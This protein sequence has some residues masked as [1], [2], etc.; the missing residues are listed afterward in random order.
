MHYRLFIIGLLLIVG[1]GATAQDRYFITF[2]DKGDTPYSIDQPLD[3]LSQRSIDRRTRNGFQVTEDDLP[4]DPTYI[5][6]VQSSGADVFFSSRWLNGV[7]VQMDASLEITVNSLDFV[8]S[9]LMVAP[10]ASLSYTQQDFEIGDFSDP[11]E[12]TRT[13]ESQINMLGID[14]AHAEG[15]TGDGVIIAVFDGG[16]AGTNNSSAFQ[17]I[18]ENDQ[19]IGEIDF[20]ENSGNPYQSD[21]YNGS[22]FNGQDHGTKVLSTI[23]ANFGASFVGAAPDADF[24][25]AVTEQVETENPVEEYN[26]L[27][28]AEYADSA[29]VDIINSSLSYGIFWSNQADYPAS[30]FD[31]QTNVVSR[32]ANFASE[33]GILVVNSAGNDGPDEGT[34]LSP[35]DSQNVLSVAS[36]SSTGDKSSFSSVGPT[37][38]G[39]TKPDIAAMGS[40]VTVVN[41]NGSIVSSSGTSYSSP[42]MAGFAACLMEAHPDWTVTELISRIKQAG[43]QSNSSDNLLGY[44]IPTFYRVQN[45]VPLAVDGEEVVVYPTPFTQKITVSGRLPRGTSYRLFNLEGQLI[46]SGGL[47]D[48]SPQ[49][50]PFEDHFKPGLYFLEL[51]SDNF[52]E[53][54]KLLKK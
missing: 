41:G 3:F 48:V 29:G 50:I 39:R 36:V 53:T 35:P 14:E 30:S 49:V 43:N 33:R 21:L 25:L 18:Y 26:W 44:G 46:M 8:E 23:A 11:P 31:G 51:R 20:V 2:K 37:Y 13:T 54:I 27:L 34:I 7:L 28:A 52:L 42:L 9:I 45:G 19:V 17:L 1:I 4:V 12:T 38:D 22:S 24:I 6:Q 5:S 16:F 10:G 40:S 15:Y 47:D 32:A